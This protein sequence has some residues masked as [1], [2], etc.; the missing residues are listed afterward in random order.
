MSSLPL[1]LCNKEWVA[2]KYSGNVYLVSHVSTLRN[3]WKKRNISPTW[4]LSPLWPFWPLRPAF[5]VWP[6]LPGGPLGP[7]IPWLPGSPGMPTGPAKEQSNL[8]LFLSHIF[9]KEGVH[10]DYT[11]L[12]EDFIS[13]T[14]LF[15]VMPFM[16]ALQASSKEPFTVLWFI[17]HAKEWKNERSFCAFEITMVM[18]RSLILCGL[19]LEAFS[20]KK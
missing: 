14:I 3:Y 7:I 18:K 12:Y 15:T 1:V 16:P 6:L 11:Y 19:I 2:R 10:L 9:E 8:S 5:P 20:L 17:S 4:P 13:F